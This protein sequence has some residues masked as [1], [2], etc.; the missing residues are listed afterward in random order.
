MS[1]SQEYLQRLAEIDEAVARA[2]PDPLV[3][4]ERA[5][6]LLAGRIG[7]RVDEAHAQLRQIATER[8]RA[9]A[10]VAQEVLAALESRPPTTRQTV[11]TAVEKV[12]RPP[13]AKRAAPRDPV[14]LPAGQQW[15]G[16]LRQVLAALPGNHTVLLPVRGPQET[17]VDYDIVAVS[18]AV[19]DLSGR[20]GEA[21]VGGRVSQIYPGIVGGAIWQAW[22]DTLADGVAREVGPVTYEGGDGPARVAISLVMRVHPIGPGLLHSWVRPDEQQRMGERIAQTER[23]GNLGWGEWD[24]LSGRIVWSEEMYRIY[25]RDPEDGPLSDEESQALRLPEDEAIHSR[26]ADAFGRGETVDITYRARIGG[27]IKHLRSVVDAVRDVQVV[28]RA[29]HRRLVRAQLGRQLSLRGRPEPPHRRQHEVVRPFRHDQGGDQVAVEGGCEDRGDHPEDAEGGGAAVGEAAPAEDGEEQVEAEFD[30]EGPV[31]GFEDVGAEGFGEHGEVG[32]QVLAG[33]LGDVEGHAGGDREQGHDGGGDE[34]AGP[35]G[36]VDAGGA[37]DEVV[38]EAASPGAHADDEAAD[39]EEDFDAEHAVDQEV[40]GDG[41][42]LGDGVGAVELPGGAVVEAGDGEGAEQAEAVH[43]EKAGLVGTV[44]CGLRHIRQVRA[45]RGRRSAEWGFRRG[46]GFG[47][48]RRRG[49][50]RRRFRRW[51]AG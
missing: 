40:A 32:G 7:C 17:V 48:R 38:A 19:V 37:G 10:E 35:V 43:G 18:P 39:E 21:V 15:A 2:R 36:G 45:V 8:G 23:L 26:A 33:E 51:C 28:D 30:P 50:V 34:C 46:R 47:R 31:G 20:P 3:L 6:G 16:S 42:L 5:A 4:V 1:S 44:C 12:L 27:R 29:Q 11:R 24:L 49:G 41:E 9:P 14:V 25:E 13:P 22:Q